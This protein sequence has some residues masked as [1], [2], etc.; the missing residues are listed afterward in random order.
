MISKR[1][2]GVSL[3]VISGILSLT[4]GKPISLNPNNVFAI[5]CISVVAFG[6]GLIVGD[7]SSN[8]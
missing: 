3:C 2:I 8:K 7:R 5:F 1:M 4:F 6:S